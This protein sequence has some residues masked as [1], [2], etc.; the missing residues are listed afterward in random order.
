MDSMCDS[1]SSKWAAI[2]IHHFN[3]WNFNCGATQ[4]R[5]ALVLNFA[6]RFVSFSKSDSQR[7]IMHAT[8]R[9]LSRTG[10]SLGGIQ[11]KLALPPATFLDVTGSALSGAWAVLSDQT[12]RD[13]YE[14][15]I[16]DH[17]I[18]DEVLSRAQNGSVLIYSLFHNL[19]QDTLFADYKFQ[20]TDFVRVV[21]PA[22]ANFHE[23]LGKL[24]NGLVPTNDADSTHE[25]TKIT[26]KLK[27]SDEEILAT[28]QGTNITE[29]FLGTNEWRKQADN[30]PDSSAAYLAHMTTPS[31]FDMCF[32]TS[33]LAA[34]FSTSAASF[35][36]CSVNEVALLRARAKVIPRDIDPTST[37]E[38]EEFRA[39][40]ELGKTLNVAAQIDVLYE[41][42]STHVASPLAAGDKISETITTTNLAVAVFEGWLSGG[43]EKD[44]RWKIAFL[45][46][47]LEFPDHLPTIER[48]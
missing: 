43:P 27:Q 11:H 25:K 5:I 30:D 42:T 37:D 6:P 3:T 9:L 44:L 15:A 23:T 4:S 34:S 7:S 1:E 45:R 21:G 33:K 8:R 20:A 10:P 16:S 17:V 48:K 18:K 47:A 41:I 31:C 38:Y 2:I 24:Q 13:L 46:E 28:L 29:A 22:L 19:H 12:S 40:D 36:E 14:Q 26:E 35:V 39:T 32:Y